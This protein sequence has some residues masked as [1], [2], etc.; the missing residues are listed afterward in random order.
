MA[1]D[2]GLYR[3]TAG[4]C[5]LHNLP[6]PHPVYRKHSRLARSVQGEQQKVST[7]LTTLLA[8]LPSGTEVVDFLFATLTSSEGCLPHLAQYL[9][10]TGH[11]GT[12]EGLLWAF[13]G[14]VDAISDSAYATALGRYIRYVVEAQAAS[15]P[16]ASQ[17]IFSYDELSRAEAWLTV[18]GGEGK[19]RYPTGASGEIL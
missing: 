17:C 18:L 6:A 12:P 5:F 14:P 11:D 16:H 13:H 4:Y 1:Y 15:G 3:K 8:G 7:E 2:S 9:E 10:E 19:R